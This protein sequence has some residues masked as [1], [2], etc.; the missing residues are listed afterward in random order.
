MAAAED[1]DTS[2]NECKSCEYCDMTKNTC[3][4]DDKKCYENGECLN[5]NCF[6]FTKGH[7]EPQ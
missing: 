5:N 7:W 4:I 3:Y 6:S 1:L 2:D